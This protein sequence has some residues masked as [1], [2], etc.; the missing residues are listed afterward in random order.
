MRVYLD[1]AHNIRHKVNKLAR[2]HVS[3][4]EPAVNQDVERWVQ[5]KGNDI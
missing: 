5:Q 2:D 4:K 3:V 1:C